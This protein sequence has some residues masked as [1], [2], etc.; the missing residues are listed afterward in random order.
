[1][2]HYITSVLLCLTLLQLFGQEPYQLFRP[3]VQYLYQ[4]DF[5]SGFAVSPLLG[6][7]VQDSPCQTTYDSVLPNLP[8]DMPDCLVRVP[9]FTGSEIC[10]DGPTTLLNLQSDEDPLWLELHQQAPLGALWL[11]ALTPDSIFARVEAIAEQGFLGLTDS[12]KSIALY[13][14]NEQG[15]LIPLYEEAPLQISR[16]YGLVR[17]VVLPW[18]GADVGNV[19]LAGLSNPLV[20]IQNPN[21]GKIFG[22]QLGDEIHLSRINTTL[23]PESFL[24]T[25]REQRTELMEQYWTPDNAQ[26]VFVFSVD[27]KKYFAGPDASTDT[28]YSSNLLDTIVINW[29]EY[30][31][32]DEQPGAIIYDRSRVLL[33]QE[34]SFC[35][36]PAK[37]LSA[38]FFT[39]TD[40][41]INE[42]VDLGA[43]S[44]FLEGL[45]G[46]Y[47]S[48]ISVGGFNFKTPKYANLQDGTICGE[49]CDF[50]VSGTTAPVSATI[51]IW[52]NPAKDQIQLTSAEE[53]AQRF[54]LSI[55]D[56]L[57]RT[58]KTEKQINLN[59]AIDIADLLPGNYW[60]LL[61]DEQ[62][63]IRLQ[64]VIIK[65]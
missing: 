58:A 3:N 6:I 42:P 39:A 24:H 22:L 28:I 53:L 2:R 18:L 21:R 38:S 59:R 31:Y 35:D 12:V 37:Q 7:K 13:L 61:Y 11:A 20:G 62:G 48:E 60:L 34:P 10:Q 64:S 5:P 52:P 33:L 49:P 55:I 40:D 9:A 65:Q 47:F 8:E 51:S 43:G 46:P 17:G 1:M 50:L 54:N 56:V 45:G 57:G 27:E 4:H 19:H 29:E 32:L 23:L 15:A 44:Y 25:Y 14:K 26:R 63:Q 36:R 16:T 41:C 30:A